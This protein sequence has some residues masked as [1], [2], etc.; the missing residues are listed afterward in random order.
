[1]SDFNYFSTNINVG[2]KVAAGFLFHRNPAV[3]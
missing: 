1:M 3:K 2:E